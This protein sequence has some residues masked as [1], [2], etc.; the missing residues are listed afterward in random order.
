REEQHLIIE[1]RPMD[2][3]EGVRVEG[4]EIDALNVR[5]EDGVRGDYAH[6]ANGAHPRIGRPEP[7]SP[8]Y[9]V[10]AFRRTVTVREHDRRDHGPAKAGHYARVAFKRLRPSGSDRFP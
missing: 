5:T 7:V 10:S 6:E 1:P 3:R 4:A 9:V 8:T 2:R